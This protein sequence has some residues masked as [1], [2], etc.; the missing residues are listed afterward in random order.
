MRDID[1]EPATMAAA[2]AEARQRVVVDSGEVQTLDIE[3]PDADRGR[4]FQTAY[5]PVFDGDRVIYVAG[6]GREV[7]DLHAASEALRGAKEHA[8]EAVRSKSRFLAAA[9]HDLRQPLQGALL[10][11]EVAM[12]E[13][14]ETA[15]GYDALSKVLLALE[16]LKNLMDSLLDVSRLDF[17]AIEPRLS[18][19]PIGT[20]I[21]QVMASCK[22]AA[23]I[24]GLRLIAIDS[25]LVVRSDATLLGRMLRNIVENAV[26]YTET[27]RVLIDCV[28]SGGQLRIEVH[29]TGAGIAAEDLDK[30][31]EEFQQLQS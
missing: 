16:D 7:T 12:A 8:E 22:S 17:G 20:V 10:F 18:D 30:I 19:F 29:D 9:S 5:A 21:E 25:S 26:R 27:G 31:W 6:I 23:E 4:S 3:Y 28:P 15:S 14:P 13:L 11:V 2:I 1:I 24:K